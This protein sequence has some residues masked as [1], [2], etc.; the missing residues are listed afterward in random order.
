MKTGQKYR[1]KY[2]EIWTK[3]MYIHPYNSQLNHIAV[4]NEEQGWGIWDNGRGL[5]QI[6]QPCSSFQTAI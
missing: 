5:S 6:P 1:D 4:W 3:K 2:G